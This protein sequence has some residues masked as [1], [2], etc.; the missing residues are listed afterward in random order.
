[1]RRDV[2]RRLLAL[3]TSWFGSP[4]IATYCRAHCRAVRAMSD[5]ERIRALE[6]AKSGED[7][8]DPHLERFSIAE[9]ERAMKDND[10]ALRAH[11]LLNEAEER[12][13]SPDPH[14]PHASNR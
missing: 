1:M 5:D 2:E 11:R 12:A 9:L 3:E 14:R 13:A 10:R 6:E 8:I 4:G 7:C